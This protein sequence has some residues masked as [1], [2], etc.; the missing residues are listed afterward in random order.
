MDLFGRQ[1]RRIAELKDWV[2]GRA[3][4]FE[5]LAEADP[6]RL[7]GLGRLLEGK[8]IVYLGEADHFVSEVFAFRLLLLRFLTPPAG[9]GGSARSWGPATGCGSIASSRAA[10][11]LG[12]HA[13]PAL[14]T[15]APRAP[16]GMT[17]SRGCSPATSTRWSRCGRRT[18]SWPGGSGVASACT[19]SG[20]TPTTRR[21]AAT[22]TWRL[23]SPPAAR[24]RAGSRFGCG[25]CPM[26]RAP[27]RWSGS[28]PRATS[29]PI[30]GPPWSKS[31][32]SRRWPSSGGRS[33]RCARG[34]PSSMPAG[35]PRPWASS[36]RRWPAARG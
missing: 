2:A 24:R 11:K 5:S 9:S 8:R 29:S 20:W 23:S 16:I 31:S 19:G 17:R 7:A 33:W 6:A 36:G 34:S 27:R 25:A 18:P 28:T 3:I 22:R 14:A 21:A 1:R 26:S 10:T 35:V 32:E 30:A 4:H 12:S 15:G 13:C